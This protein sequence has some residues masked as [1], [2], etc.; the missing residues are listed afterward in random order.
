MTDKKARRGRGVA[1]PPA[2]TGAC[3]SALHRTCGIPSK[4]RAYFCLTAEKTMIGQ[5]AGRIVVFYISSCHEDLR[6]YLSIHS[7]NAL[8]SSANDP[9]D[10]V[11]SMPKAIERPRRLKLVRPD[12]E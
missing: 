5:T 2:P 3:A 8:K 1:G 11:Y 4:V 10:N 6:W 7:P 9:A 12:G